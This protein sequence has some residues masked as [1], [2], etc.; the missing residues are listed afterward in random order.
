MSTLKWRHY[1]NLTK[2]YII[3]LRK[4]LVDCFSIDDCSSSSESLAELDPLAVHHQHESNM[5]ELRHLGA[6]LNVFSNT[7]TNY[8]MPTSITNYNIQVTLD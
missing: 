5:A 4:P 2:C 3:A 1:D 7:V 8:N 6:Q